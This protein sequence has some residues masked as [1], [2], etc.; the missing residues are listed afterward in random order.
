MK[1]LLDT[2]I[3]L[4]LLLERGQFCN[5]AKNIFL[6]VEEKK[7][8]GFLSASSITTI[9]YLVNKSLSKDEANKV[10][11]M[12]LMLFEVAPLNKNIFASALENIGVDFEDSVIYSCA[13]D[14]KIDYIITRDKKGF[15]TSKVSALTPMEFLGFY[16][17]LG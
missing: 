3:V 12:L 2:N 1:I 14:S 13:L 4:D 10:I 17:S 16:K 11:T 15:N 9:H 7:I 5:A 6:L 8:R